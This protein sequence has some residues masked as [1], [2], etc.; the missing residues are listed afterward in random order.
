MLF[1]SCSPVRNYNLKGTQTIKDL[2]IHSIINKDNSLLY[3]AKITIYNKYY[4]GLILLKQTDASTAHLVFVTELGMKMFDFEIQNNHL[5][6]IYVFEPLNK[7]G[8]LKLLENDMG[9]ILLIKV[10][11]RDAKIYEK[12]DK[13]QLIYKTTEGKLKNYYLLNSTTKTVNQIIV[14]GSLFTKETVSYVYNDSLNAKQIKLKHKGI[15]PVKIELNSISNK[16]QQ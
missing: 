1:I 13:S 2:D 3:K 8:I 15:L 4:S 11:N 9:L 6:L 10:L 7:P 5:K 14:K 12:K 16:V